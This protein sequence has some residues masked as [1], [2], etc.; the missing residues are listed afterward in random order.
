MGE[1]MVYLGQ[2]GKAVSVLIDVGEV[3]NNGAF[4][5]PVNTVPIRYSLGLATGRATCRKKMR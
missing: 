2:Y 1:R 3:M 4:D 5:I